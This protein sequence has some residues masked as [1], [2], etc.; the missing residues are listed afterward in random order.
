VSNLNVEVGKNFF[1]RGG[2]TYGLQFTGFFQEASVSIPETFGPW[3]N[4]SL[5]MTP[6]RILM[7]F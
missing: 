6:E 2:V 3:L 1:E 4:K 5:K 7:C